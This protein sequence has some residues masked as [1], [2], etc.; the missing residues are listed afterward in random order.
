[1]TDRFLPLLAAVWLLASASACSAPSAQQAEAG[2]HSA[3]TSALSAATPY[4]ETELPDTAGLGDRI[5]AAYPGWRL[6]TE[7]EIGERFPLLDGTTPQSYWREWGSGQVWWVWSGDFDGDGRKDRLAILTSAADPSEDKLVVLH[8]D[9]THADLGP[10]GG[11]GVG[12]TEK[13]EELWGAVLQ[14]DA[15]AKVYWDKGADLVVWHPA[16]R[17]YEPLESDCC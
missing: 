6:S 17:A 7:R 16:T 15:I 12:V 1:M 13:G 8:T 11:W 14:S 5:A 3:A 10:L 2:T 9:G 4:Q